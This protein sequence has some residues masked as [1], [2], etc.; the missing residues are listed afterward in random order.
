MLTFRRD[1]PSDLVILRH[2]VLVGRLY[3]GAIATDTPLVVQRPTASQ[4]MIAAFLGVAN[5]RPHEGWL[6]DLDGETRAFSHKG[7]ARSWAIQ[8]EER[9]SA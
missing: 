6:V 9:R 8:A 2:G 4:A 3:W 7:L 5:R 1:G